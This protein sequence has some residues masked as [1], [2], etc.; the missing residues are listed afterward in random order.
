ME[1]GFEF[2]VGLFSTLAAGA[3]LVL[4]VRADRFLRHIIKT[5]EQK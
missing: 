1:V 3:G 4:A 5:I 2:L